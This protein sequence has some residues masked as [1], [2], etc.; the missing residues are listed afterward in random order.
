MRALATALLAATLTTGCGGGGGGGPET[1]TT[2]II[3]TFTVDGTVLEGSV[4]ANGLLNLG[5][6]LFVGDGPPT[7]GSP[8]IGMRVFIDFDLA[9]IPA[10]AEVLSATL[11]V[12]QGGGEGI[13]FASLGD[14]VVDQVVFGLV[15]DAG[16]YDRSFPVNQGIAFSADIVLGSQIAT[17]TSAVRDDVDASVG[18]T[19][20]RIRFEIETNA[21]MAGDYVHLDGPRF[22][23]FPPTLTVTYR[24]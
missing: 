13:P 22:G 2:T 11:S 9:S 7:P 15:L 12:T 21:D 19:Q 8:D 3:S 5:E 23:E 1:V 16:A 20:F 18:R 24:H 4:F 17:V 10:G 14:L 6:N